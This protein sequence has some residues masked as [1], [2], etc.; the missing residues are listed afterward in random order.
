MVCT[1]RSQE[2][3]I[4]CLRVST[5]SVLSPR[6]SHRSVSTAC[7]REED[8]STSRTL[9]ANGDRSY[10]ETGGQDAVVKPWVWCLLMFLGPFSGTVLVQAYSFITVRTAF[11]KDHGQSDLTLSRP[12][13]LCTWRVC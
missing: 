13:L 3:S 7:S 2:G 1:D 12:K 8:S 10:L 5:P 4:L 9:F 11:P 6:S